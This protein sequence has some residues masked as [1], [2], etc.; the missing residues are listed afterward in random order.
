MAR[1]PQK[2]VLSR[3]ADVSEAAIQRL[4]E[5]PGGDRIAGAAT[6]VRDRLDELQ[7]RVRGLEGLEQRI[8][9]LERKVDQLT[10]SGGSSGRSTSTSKKTSTPPKKTT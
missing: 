8:A 7:R 1:A 5:M 3:L 9:E 10:K 4:G 6:T 2:D